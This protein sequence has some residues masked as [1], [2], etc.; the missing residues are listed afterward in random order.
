MTGPEHERHHRAADSAPAPGSPP[1][2]GD[3]PL[4]V[5][6]FP[7][8]APTQPERVAAFGF[9]SLLAAAI[10]A[11]SEDTSPDLSAA[12]VVATYEWYREQCRRE[13]NP[14]GAEFT[15]SHALG[16]ARRQLARAQ[17]LKGSYEPAAF[18]VG[19]GVY[20]TVLSR[21]AEAVG[22]DPDTIPT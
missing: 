21:I 13:W 8:E 15:L 2:R 14:P 12:R 19:I 20:R 10:H 18:A 11:G 17:G 3:P 5:R 22:I 9:T 16:A 6:L 1:D 4:S 7:E